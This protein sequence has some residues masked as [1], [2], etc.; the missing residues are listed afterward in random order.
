MFVYYC[1]QGRIYQTS[2]PTPQRNLQPPRRNPTPKN[3]PFCQQKVLFFKIFRL[4]EP[5]ILSL[6]YGKIPSYKMCY[7][8]QFFSCSG[9]QSCTVEECQWL[10]IAFCERGGA[11]CR[12]VSYVTAIPISGSEK[13]LYST[14]V[15]VGVQGQ[16]SW[17]HNSQV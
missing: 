4:Q 10:L 3:E 5:F 1:I 16:K 6:F 13:K 12:R 2:A 15:R 8:S 7:F 9:L 17:K 14:H 11:K